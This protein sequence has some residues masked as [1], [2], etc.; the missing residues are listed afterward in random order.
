MPKRKGQNTKY[1]VLG[2]ILLIVI[3]GVAVT[4]SYRP[5]A[6]PRATQYLE[7]SHTRS[8]GKLY[9]QNRTAVL[10]ILGLNITAIG[11]DAHNIIIEM[12]SQ[13]DP[14]NDFLDVL[15][16]GTS[17]DHQISLQSALGGVQGLETVLNEQGKF[18][19]EI[20]IG[21]AEATVETVTVFIDPKDIVQLG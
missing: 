3:V 8:I 11:G 7:V 16:N 4:L 13:A 20:T 14:T 6:K 18:P 2:V 9:D 12:D 1:L 19:V 15:P 21:C 5:T 17:W 10:T